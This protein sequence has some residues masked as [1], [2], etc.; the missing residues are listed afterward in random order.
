MRRLRL[1][2]WITLVWT[3]LYGDVSWAN[4][5]GGL[6]VGGVVLV[7]VPLQGSPATRRIGVLAAVRYSAVFARD[8][9]V[10][11]AQVA[12]QVFW[13]IDRLRPAVVAVQ[14]D[15]TDRG[16]LALVADTITLTP[17]TLTLEVDGDRGRLWVHVLHLPEGGAG[18]VV[19]QARGLERLGAR[20]LGVDLAAAPRGP[21]GPARGGVP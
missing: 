13:P 2:A 17:G 5:V 4:L 12:V 11:S 3:A 14:L 16:L 19:E 10:A 21:R 6:L 15:S 20:V 9:V 1:A 7:A 18:A 8:L